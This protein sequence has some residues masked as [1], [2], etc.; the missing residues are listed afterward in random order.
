MRLFLSYGQDE[1]TPLTLRL[2]SDLERRLH[3]AWFDQ[4]LP[5][6]DSSWTPARC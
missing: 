6:P 1:H 3:Q 2:K 5:S 4:H